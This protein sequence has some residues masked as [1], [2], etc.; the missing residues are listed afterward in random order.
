MW[1]TC[2]QGICN[3]NLALMAVNL[4]TI[5]FLHIPVEH[6]GGNK[7]T[8]TRYHSRE[9]LCYPLFDRKISVFNYFKSQ[10]VRFTFF[11][12]YISNHKTVINNRYSILC[13]CNVM[14]IST[15]SG[16][17]IGHGRLSQSKRSPCSPMKCSVNPDNLS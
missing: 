4:I 8:H 10:M 5:F 7:L 17:C 12:A 2:R 3:A 6:C 16:I 13:F 11:F 1:K 14:Q 9:P 15:K